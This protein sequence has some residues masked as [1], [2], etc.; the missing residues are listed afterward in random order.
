MAQLNLYKNTMKALF[1][2]R[3]F[4]TKVDLSNLVPNFQTQAPQKEKRI[5]Y[6]DR[7]IQKLQKDIKPE[8]NREFFK[9]NADGSKQ[10]VSD[11]M[12][13]HGISR[14]HQF[15]EGLVQKYGQNF[16]KQLNEINREIHEQNANPLFKQKLQKHSYSSPNMGYE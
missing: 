8:E 6:R 10:S 9:P 7:V 4:T 3:R 1:A 16:G 13:K 14:S 11:V 12:K 2:R 5:H 15:Q